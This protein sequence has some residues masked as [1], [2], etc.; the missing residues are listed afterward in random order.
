MEYQCIKN[1]L[2]SPIKFVT[3]RKCGAEVLTLGEILFSVISMHLSPGVWNARY[4]HAK[5][6]RE[7]TQLK[8]GKWIGKPECCIAVISIVGNSLFTTQA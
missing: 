2:S 7:T 1:D 3:A 6:V 8:L 4:T 5:A